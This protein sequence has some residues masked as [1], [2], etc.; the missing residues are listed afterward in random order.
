MQEGL[1]I[2]LTLLFLIAANGRVNLQ[3]I[4][5]INVNYY[6]PNNS[7]GYTPQAMR[8]IIRLVSQFQKHSDFS[9]TYC[10]V[11]NLITTICFSGNFIPEFIL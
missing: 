2:I 11:I 6:A 4:E 7:Y 10:T 3:K 1:L 8:I 5:G 9:E